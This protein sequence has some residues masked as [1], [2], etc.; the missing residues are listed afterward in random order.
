VLAFHQLLDQVVAG[1]IL[2]VLLAVRQI[3][4]H[5]MAAQ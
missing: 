5:L 3:K 1:G 4:N 2:A